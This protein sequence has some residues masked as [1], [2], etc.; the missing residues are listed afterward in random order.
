MFFKTER[1]LQL[2]LAALDFP[3]FQSDCEAYSRREVRVGGCIPDLI[4][5]SFTKK[6]DV[7]AWPKRWSYKHSYITWLLRQ[8]EDLYIHEIA[9]LMYVPSERIKP[10]LNNLVESEILCETPKGTLSLSRSMKN[11]RGHVLAVEA[12]LRNW[13]EALSQAITY[14]NFANT[15]FV[16]MDATSVPYQPDIL[17]IF[18]NE[19]IGLCAVSPGSTEWLVEPFTRFKVASHQKEYLMMSVANPNTQILW[20]RRND[21]KAS[22]QG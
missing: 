15:V 10:I 14:K 9:G 17:S 11:I 4:H 19:D 6:L 20:S 2:E 22:Y 12:K 16:A 1:D 13:R 8:H 7:P 3:L 18:E 21:S 5:V